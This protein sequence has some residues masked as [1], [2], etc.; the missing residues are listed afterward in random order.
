MAEP[1]DRLKAALAGRYT[2]ERELGHGGMATVYLAEDR[3]HHR[4]VAVKVLRPE[5]VAALGPERFLR[6]IEIAAP[7]NHPHILP[8]LDSGVAGKRG[9]GDGAFLYYVMPYVEGESLRDRLTREPQLPL[10][11]A[12]QI[13]KEVADA[14][15]YAHAHQVIHRDIKPENILLESGHAVVADFGIAKAIVAAGREQL[16]EAGQ[17]VGTPAYMSPEQASGRQDL[18]GRSDLYS[19]GCVLYEMLAGETPYTGPTPQSILAKKLSE[20]LPR[21][22]VVRDTVPAEVEAT[23]TKVLART[24]A[25]RFHTAADFVEALAKPIRRERSH[26]GRRLAFAGVTVLA[27]AT[28]IVVL[29]TRSTK[30]P[31]STY[32]LVIDSTVVAVLPFRLVSTDTAST[33][34]Q[35]AQGLPDLFAMKITGEFGPRIAYPPSVQKLWKDA[36][37]TLGTPLDG[38][39]ELR[40]ARAV[41]AGKLIRGSLVA[42]DTSLVLT[43]ELVAV[44]SG[45]VRVRSTSVEGRRDEWLVM[46][47]RLAWQLLAQDQGIPTSRLP[48]L[49]RFKPRAIQAMLAGNQTIDLKKGN[50]LYRA[51]FT[52]DSTMVAAALAVYANGEGDRDSAYVR[53]AWEHQDQLTP[54]QRA[55]LLPL[56]GW[57]FGATRTEAERIAQ[58][59]A[60]AEDIPESHFWADLGYDLAQYGPIASVPNWQAAA[61][62]ALE[63]AVRVDPKN[64]WAWWHLLEL[65]FLAEDTALIQQRL[66]HF[67]ATAPDGFLAAQIPGCRWRLAMLRGDTVEAGRLLATQSESGSVPYDAAAVGRGLAL[68][69]RVMQKEVGEKLLNNDDG[70]YSRWRGYYRQWQQGVALSAPSR[71][72]SAWAAWLVRDALFLDGPQDSVVTVQAAFLER[73]AAGRAS[74]APTRRQRTQ[75]RCWSALWRVAHGDT[76]STQRV[77][78]QL[79]REAEPSYNSAG[80]V[81][82]ITV[83]LTRAR[84]GNVRAA[85]VRLDSVVRDAPLPAGFL[86]LP[87]PPLEEVANLTLARL[88]AHYGD[89]ARALAASRRRIYLRSHEGLYQ[90]LPEFLR[91]EG[92][93]AAATGDRTGAI[94]AYS[95]YLTLRENPD[96]APWRATRDS[97]RRELAQ[98]VGEP[99]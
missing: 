65:A 62:Q 43:G 83:F 93:L 98:L 12:L 52:A 91:E 42:T 70:T 30:D 92:R 59:R 28:G 58:Y 87:F 85:L 97:V 88:L 33:L 11:D 44:P 89:T 17:A 94:R 45:A 71:P 22:S 81:G 86:A 31:T 56:A 14:L 48:Q 50:D 24:P 79:E 75:A 15:G 9:T 34:R 10:N 1:P 49:A 27:A 39:G 4:H 5:V 29:K 21:V 2:I 77:L 7:L 57:R 76:A 96:Y 23:L 69:D 95:R 53:F 19:L 74:P 60:L 18:D 68:A 73:I 78:Q 41:G 38:D 63:T 20:P 67:A 13:T 82:L 8:L 47:D 90:S 72:P 36:G 61:R 16:T 84:G 54:S 6:E 66:E 32:P 26:R 51:A 40:V 37:G 35:L 80:C 46:V 55:Y 64:G 3:K 99:R 25:D